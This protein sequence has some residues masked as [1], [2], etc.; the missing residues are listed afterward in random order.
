[1]VSPFG[2]RC[3]PFVFNFSVRF[4]RENRTLNVNTN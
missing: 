1:M 3:S 2:V 4:R